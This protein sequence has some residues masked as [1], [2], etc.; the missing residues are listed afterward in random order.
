[1]N[2]SMFRNFNKSNV[3]CAITMAGLVLF[4]GGCTTP[5]MLENRESIPPATLTPSED[6]NDIVSNTPDAEVTLP[7]DVSEVTVI[8]VDGQE[9][10][11][12]GFPKVKAPAIEYKVKK[13]DSFWKIGRMY[14]V[15]M[16]E[17]AAYNNMDINKPLN[18]GE[19]LDIPPGG[20]LIS[21]DEFIPIKS[22]KSPKKLSPKVANAKDG[23]YTVRPGDSLWLIA[24]RNNTTVNK[25]TEANG[26]NKNTPLKVGH[27]LILPE[28]S[29]AVKAAAKPVKDAS[30]SKTDDDLLNDLIDNSKEVTTQ[31]KGMVSSALDIDTESCLPHTIKAGDTWNTISEM[32][33]VSVADLKKANSKIASEKEPKVD[34]VINIPES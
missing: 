32:Y 22:K 25:L 5:K 34:T 15:G 20:K 9:G 13:G 6:A 30:L 29:K 2:K 27:K 21:K 4:I 26:I 17:L 28:G 11:F 1:M 14:G 19:V 7:V 31:S 12:P 24:R 10:D 23:T 16:K 33:G 3:I 8:T 18:A